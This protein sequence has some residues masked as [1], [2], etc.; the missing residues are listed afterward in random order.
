M[1]KEQFELRRDAL[2]STIKTDGGA[3]PNPGH[4][5]GAC[6]FF[7]QDGE[8]VGYRSRYFGTDVSNNLAE[9][10]GVQLAV[11]SIV[12]RKLGAVDI[13]TDSKLVVTNIKRAREGRRIQSAPL[14]AVAK[15]LALKLDSNPGVSVSWISRDLVT[16]PHEY[17]QDQLAGR[18][19][20][21]PRITPMR[22]II[23]ELS[24]LARDTGSLGLEGF[25][26]P[27]VYT[28]SGVHLVGIPYYVHK[29]T[30]LDKMY[31]PSIDAAQWRKARASFKDA[32]TYMCWRPYGGK[33]KPLGV[34]SIVPRV[35]LAAH[36]AKDGGI[37]MLTADVGTLRLDTRIQDMLGYSGTSVYPLKGGPWRPFR[38][39]FG[40]VV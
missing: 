12:M 16:E 39:V 1:I 34:D 11:D 17:V 2:V 25:D 15:A 30:E 36:N 4:G 3:K 31:V 7:D 21:E 33:E 8:E 24:E 10:L 27:I 6:V 13:F 23:V 22:R 29:D 19:Y 38:E 37:E 28:Q 5:A 9:H 14:A 40:Y 20:I 32:P 26:S 35:R 18:P